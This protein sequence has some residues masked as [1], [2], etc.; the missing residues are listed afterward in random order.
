[1]GSDINR[2]S[3]QL[4]G[5]SGFSYP[6]FSVLISG[7]G[8][9]DKDNPDSTLLEPVCGEEKRMRSGGGMKFGID[10]RILSI[11]KGNNLIPVYFNDVYL[12][13]FAE[14][15]YSSDWEEPMTTVGGLITLETSALYILN[16]EPS[17]GVGYRID[18]NKAYVLWGISGTLGSTGVGIRARMYSKFPRA[19][20]MFDFN[21]SNFECSME[22]AFQ[23]PWKF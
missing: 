20:S 22:K 23:M 6:G 15:I 1:M 19:K 8:I 14:I 9:W 5:G 4:Y 18:E 10:Y 3:Y 17:I 12:R 11:E 21:I 7:I 2:K 13:P 16:L